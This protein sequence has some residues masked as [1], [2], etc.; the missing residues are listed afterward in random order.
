MIDEQCVYTRVIVEVLKAVSFF[1]VRRRLQFW[2][3]NSNKAHYHIVNDNSLISYQNHSIP[4]RTKSNKL[5][6]PNKIIKIML[7]GLKILK[8][9]SNS[10]KS[11]KIVCKIN[12]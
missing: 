12:K 11:N 5:N 9:T 4:K 6:S 10:G 7:F 3:Y 8:L 1:T 2:L